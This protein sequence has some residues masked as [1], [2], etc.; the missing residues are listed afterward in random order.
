MAS[1]DLIPYRY[2]YSNVNPEGTLILA[3]STTQ[4]FSVSNTSPQVVL[5][6][7]DASGLQGS[8]YGYLTNYPLMVKLFCSSVTPDSTGVFKVSA[9]GSLGSAACERRNA[10]S[11]ALTWKVRNWEDLTDAD[12]TVTITPRPPVTSVSM[13]CVCGLATDNIDRDDEGSYA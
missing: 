9:S 1:P 13:T 2:V 4:E 5:G 6:P 7:F 8:P 11:F 3:D 12:A 10:D